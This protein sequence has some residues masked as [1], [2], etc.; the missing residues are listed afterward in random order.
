MTIGVFMFGSKLD[1]RSRKPKHS[2]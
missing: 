1:P 2:T